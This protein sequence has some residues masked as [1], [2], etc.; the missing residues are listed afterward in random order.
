MSVFEI[1]RPQYNYDSWKNVRVTSLETNSLS[2]HGTGPSYGPVVMNG[3]GAFVPTMPSSSLSLPLANLVRVVSTSSASGTNQIYQCPTG[4]KAGVY[5]F[6]VYNQYTGATANFFGEILFN[7]TGVW[8]HTTA[9]NSVATGTRSNAIGSSMVLN[10]GDQWSINVSATG[11]PLS[12]N[13]LEFP[14]SYPLSS[15]CINPSTGIQTILTCTTGTMWGLGLF[16]ALN[17]Q[18]ISVTLLNWSGST[19]IFQ[20]FY[21]PSGGTRTPWATSSVANNAG[22]SV[23]LGVIM[24]PG[25]VIEV[26]SN[27]TSTSQFACANVFQA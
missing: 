2:Y 3:S 21:T 1:L 18:Q 6:S 9:S 7:G 11:I 14:S 4:T 10:A 22:S 13:F 19:I 25:D 15:H 16:T 5:N 12:A 8:N 27:S 17:T 24:G 20:L 23:A 26:M